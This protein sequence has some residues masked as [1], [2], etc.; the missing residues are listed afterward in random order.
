[1]VAVLVLLALLLLA[2]AYVAKSS[3]PQLRDRASDSFTAAQAA[4][5]SSVNRVLLAMSR[6]VSGL[7]VAHLDEES[8]TY[9]ALRT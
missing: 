8:P 9:K 6:P 7:A 3:D 2:S 4:E 5:S 1:M